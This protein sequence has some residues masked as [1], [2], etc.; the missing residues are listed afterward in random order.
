MASNT[1]GRRAMRSISVLEAIEEYRTYNR[2]QSYSPHYVASSDRNLQEFARWLAEEGRSDRIADLTID[3]ARAFMI[4]VQERENRVR[5]GTR[6]APD[7]VQ[8]YARNLKSWA[9]FCT[10]R[11]MPAATC[12]LDCASLRCP[13]GSRRC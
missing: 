1:R 3:D 11:D 2:A 8:Q 9:G 6:L 4:Y 5:P 7:S 13:Y 10:E 12:W